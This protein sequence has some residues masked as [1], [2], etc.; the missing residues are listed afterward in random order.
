[1]YTSQFARTLLYLPG[2]QIPVP[3]DGRSVV[4][5][6]GHLGDNLPR[7]RPGDPR[8]VLP[9]VVPVP[10]AAIV[11]PP[12]R[13]YLSLGRQHNGVSRTAGDL[14]DPDPPEG[15][16]V[17]RFVLVGGVA[18]TQ[19]AVLSTAPGK[20]RQS[21]ADV[22]VLDDAASNVGGAPVISSTAS[23]GTEAVLFAQRTTRRGRR[24]GGSCSS[25]RH[26]SIKGK[27]CVS[28]LVCFA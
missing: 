28:D 24:F 2:V 6:A 10:E 11:P 7:Q 25:G 3:G 18:E 9:A 27:G 21:A 26:A 15:V 1:M 14:A 17:G 20:D 8:N 4:R 19:L 12:P 16:D 23:A 5:P 22:L 13:V